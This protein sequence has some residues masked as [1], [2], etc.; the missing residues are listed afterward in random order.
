[1]QSAMQLFKTRDSVF[2]LRAGRPA[3]IKDNDL[4]D[5]AAPTLLRTRFLR[6][7][8]LTSPSATDVF[9]G[10]T[11]EDKAMQA[12]LRHFHDQAMRD[13]R[14]FLVLELD[15]WFLSANNWTF[16]SKTFPMLDLHLTVLSTNLKFVLTLPSFRRRMQISGPTTWA[17]AHFDIHKIAAIRDAVIATPDDSVA[18]AGQWSLVSALEDVQAWNESVGDPLLELDRPSL[19]NDGRKQCAECKRHTG[20]V[21]ER[22]GRYSGEVLCERCTMTQEANVA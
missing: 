11:I 16:L 7:Y 18:T 17:A 21:W 3:R 13:E 19:A 15:G 12:L 14:L 20:L 4:P 5:L 1:M 8:I 9:A 6:P 10:G 2:G 22:D